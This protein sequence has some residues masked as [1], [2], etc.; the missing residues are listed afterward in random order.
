MKPLWDDTLDAPIGSD[1]SPALVG[2]IV[3]RGQAE[4][5]QAAGYDIAQA[6]DRYRAFL[7]AWEAAGSEARAD[8]ILRE[9]YQSEQ[10]RAGDA[11]ITASD[12]DFHRLATAAKFHEWA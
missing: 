2:H 7:A 1:G 5:W 9:F 12:A 3:T 11:G 8:E 6:V 4:R 10:A